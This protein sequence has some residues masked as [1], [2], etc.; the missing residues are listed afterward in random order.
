[1]LGSI[2]IGVIF[3]MV[4]GGYLLAGGKLGIIMKSLPFELMMIGGA[5]VGAFLVSNDSHVLK[6]TGKDIAK[7]LKGPK[8]S[9]ADYRDLLCLLFELIRLARHNP[10]AYVWRC[11][12]RASTCRRRAGAQGHATHGWRQGMSVAQ[13]AT[14]G[15]PAQYVAAAHAAPC[16][17]P[18]LRT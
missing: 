5:A 13:R 3:V 7:V 11:D 2:G 6:Q 18:Y 15:C 9:P 16:V 1:M 8:W 10:G 14:P 12:A 17:P 4:F